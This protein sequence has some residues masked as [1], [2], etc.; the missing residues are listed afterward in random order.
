MQAVQ[1]LSEFVQATQ[2]GLQLEQVLRTSFL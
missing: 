2:F 1:L